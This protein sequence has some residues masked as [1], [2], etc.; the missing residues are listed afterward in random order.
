MTALANWGEAGREAVEQER[1]AKRKELL[2]EAK[3]WREIAKIASG[4]YRGRIGNL[5][6]ER[7]KYCGPFRH[8]PVWSQL[9]RREAEHRRVDGW[10]PG[11]EW[12]VA[13]NLVVLRAL[14]LALEA[15]D[16]AAALSS[17]S[18]KSRRKTEAQQ[19]SAGRGAGRARG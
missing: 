5:W 19:R 16:E 9:L 14:F 3:A 1:A 4:C 17:P 2:A 10:Q 7:E 6:V 13:S 18:R 15:A 8:R 12:S 11:S